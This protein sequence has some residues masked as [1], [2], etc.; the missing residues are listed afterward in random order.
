MDALADRNH[1][2]NAGCPVLEWKR[3]QLE[4][5][6]VATMAIGSSR[7]SRPCSDRRAVQSADASDGEGLATSAGRLPGRKGLSG[8]TAP[9]GLGSQRRHR[10]SCARRS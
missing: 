4:D 7:A 6:A 9:T 10:L 5:E 3:R 1:R 2:S 8:T